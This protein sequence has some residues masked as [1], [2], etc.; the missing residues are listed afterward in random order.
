[1][2]ERI[3]E[4]KV[5]AVIEKYSFDAEKWKNRSAQARIIQDLGINS[6]RVVDIVIDLEEMFDIEVDDESLESISTVN[7]IVQILVKKLN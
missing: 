1:M 5:F 4:R 6:A 2:D 3:L 7:D